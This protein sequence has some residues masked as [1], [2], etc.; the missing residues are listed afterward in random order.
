VSPAGEH[1]PRTLRLFFALWP[2]DHCRAALAKAAASVVA[3]VDGQPVPPGNLHV[4]LAF[5]GKVVGRGFADLVSVGG[6]GP[7]PAVDLAFTRIEY[8]A[9]PR[10]LVALP[11]EVPAAACAMVDR[12]WDGLEP[13]GF[14]REQRPWQPHLTLVRRVRRAPPGDLEMAPCTASGPE[15]AWRLALV[16]S[17]ARP[18]GVRY[19]PLADWQLGGDAPLHIR[20]GA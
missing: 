7:W 6:R 14:Q 18:D 2:N 8:W 4:T 5:L 10:T 16:E 3:R 20:E 19:K 17:I 1:G 15:P 12:L 13:L 9:K 11:S